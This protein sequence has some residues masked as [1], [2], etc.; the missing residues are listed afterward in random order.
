MHPTDRRG[1]VAK[2]DPA[3]E[4][5][6]PSVDTRL[7]RVGLGHDAISSGINPKK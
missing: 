2:F 1:C 3:R 6:E 5:E 7:L 4:E